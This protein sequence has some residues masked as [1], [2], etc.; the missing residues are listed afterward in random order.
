MLGR[1]CCCCGRPGLRVQTAPGVV[2]HLCQAHLDHHSPAMPDGFPKLLEPAPH[3]PTREPKSKRKAQ[4][5]KPGST[6]TPPLEDPK[7]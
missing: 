6:S 5:P 3:L 7:P 4:S 2:Q 1:P